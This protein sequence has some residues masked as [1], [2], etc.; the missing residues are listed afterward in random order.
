MK[1]GRFFFFFAMIWLGLAALT[2]GAAALGSFV[3]HW[4]LA[5]WA[6]VTHW[7]SPP[8]L[9]AA[10]ITL[11][12]GGGALVCALAWG[13]VLKLVGGATARPRLKARPQSRRRTT[14]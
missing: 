9:A 10:A 13:L 8:I 11:L 6:R 14:V 2:A 1:M 7:Y 12:S 5:S 4:D 3:L